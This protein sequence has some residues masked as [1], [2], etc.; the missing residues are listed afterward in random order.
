MVMFLSQIR[1][2][3][4]SWVSKDGDRVADGSITKN[5]MNHIDIARLRRTGQG[6][7]ADNRAMTPVYRVGE[8]FRRSVRTWPEGAEFSHSPAGFE[9]TLFRQKVDELAIDAVR[10]GTAE[11]ALIV[12]PPVLVVAYQF[13]E[14]IPWSDVPYYWHTRSAG[15]R[16]IPLARPQSGDRALLWITLV[17]TETGIIHA[18]RGVTLSPEF[19]SHLTNVIRSQAMAAADPTGCTQA[20]SRLFLDYPRTIDRLPFAKVRSQGNE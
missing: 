14:V 12:E 17:E 3:G 13:G 1:R 20:I 2:E 9:L 4:T 5:I 10:S 18:Q 6:R 8:C 7:S 19:T 15:D 16:Q 11:F